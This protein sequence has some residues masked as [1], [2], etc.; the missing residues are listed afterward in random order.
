[1]IKSGFIINYARSTWS[2]IQNLNDDTINHSNFISTSSYNDK[3]FS[4]S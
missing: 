1:M 4:K 2:H 3:F